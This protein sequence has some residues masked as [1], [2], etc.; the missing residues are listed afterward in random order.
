MAEDNETAHCLATCDQCGTAFAAA[1]TADGDLLPL[2][3]R[4]GCRC[5]ST[6]FSRVEEKDFKESVKDS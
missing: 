6:S 2:G 1:E 5:G 3:S 4:N